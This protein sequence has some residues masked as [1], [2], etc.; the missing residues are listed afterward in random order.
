MNDLNNLLDS[1]DLIE[2][3]FTGPNFSWSNKSFGSNLKASKIDKCFV[4]ADWIASFPNFSVISSPLSCF[5]AKSFKALKRLNKEG[6]GNINAL[7]KQVQTKLVEVQNLLEDDPTIIALRQEE[8][9][10]MDSLINNS[11]HEEILLKQKS[12]NLWLKEGDSNSRIFFKS[13]MKRR[14]LNSIRSIYN[15]TG[16]LLL[17][18][19]E[20]IRDHIVEFYGKLLG[21]STP[22]INKQSKF[23]SLFPEDVSSIPA[24]SLT[25]RRNGIFK[26]IRELDDFKA[27]GNIL[28]AIHVPVILK[29]CIKLC[30]STPKYSININGERCGYF[31]V[32][33][34]L[35][36]INSALY[37]VDA[38]DEFSA[39]T[40][41]QLNP[42]KSQV[43][44]PGLI[45]I[46]KD[47]ILDHLPF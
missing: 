2:P 8:R 40:G 29:D 3:P 19:E 46:E 23:S 4:N 6:F 10:I 17:E 43:Y 26:V 9:N 18:E 42:S 1:I 30:Y 15:E 22:R 38:L 16:V 35:R 27:P 11:R 34:D 36:D 24:L 47:F 32:A 5:Q 33:R 13:L 25:F 39:L 45:A 21:T 12:R 41:L 28:E 7:V 20:L 44:F 14:A 31:K 37:L